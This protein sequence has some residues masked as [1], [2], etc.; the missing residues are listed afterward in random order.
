MNRPDW[1]GYFAGKWRMTRAIDDRRGGRCGVGEG[2]TQFTPGSGDESLE[3]RETL[4]IDYGGRKTAGEQ[5]TSWRFC[6]AAGPRL[7]FK[8]GRFFCAMRFI[9]NAASWRASLAHLCGADSYNADVTIINDKS[10]RLVW[11]VCGPR[12]DYSLDTAYLRD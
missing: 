4:I 11:R 7:Y 9:R 3:C 8:D 5:M 2:V 1:R 12:K 10:W 6:D